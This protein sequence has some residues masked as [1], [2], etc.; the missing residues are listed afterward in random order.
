[1]LIIG[2]YSDF[3][4]QSS[5]AFRDWGVSNSVFSNPFSSAN[6]KAPAPDRI[7]CGVSSITLRATLTGCKICCR[8]QTEPALPVSSITHASRVTRPSLSGSPPRPTELL[9]GSASVTLTPCSTASIALPL[10]DR[11]FQASSLAF[12][13]KSQVDKTTGPPGPDGVE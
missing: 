7:T 13:P 1:M 3:F 5:Q 6:F 2:L 10:D 9:L 8:K 12:I 11:I 4:F